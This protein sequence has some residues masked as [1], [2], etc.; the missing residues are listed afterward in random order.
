MNDSTPYSPGL[1]PSTDGTHA[2]PLSHATGFHTSDARSTTSNL[3]FNLP[4]HD[5][6]LNCFSYHCKSDD[7][8]FLRAMEEESDDC[9]RRL[10]W[11][12]YCIRKAAP[13]ANRSKREQVWHTLVESDDDIWSIWENG[14]DSSLPTAPTPEV[15][16]DS[17]F[18]DWGVITPVISRKIERHSKNHCAPKLTPLLPSPVLVQNTSAHMRLA[19]VL[20]KTLLATRRVKYPQNPS[21]VNCEIPSL[22]P[23]WW[24]MLPKPVKD[25]LV[26]D[27]R[28]WDRFCMEQQRRGHTCT[29][30]LPEMEMWSTWIT[31]QACIGAS[32]PLNIS[33]DDE[34]CPQ[35][36]ESQNILDLLD[37]PYPYPDNVWDS[38]HIISHYSSWYE[39]LNLEESL[40]NQTT[41]C[42]V[43]EWLTDIWL[44]SDQFD[45]SDLWKH[46]GKTLDHS[47]FRLQVY[48]HLNENSL[49]PHWTEIQTAISKISS[50]E[51]SVDSELD[52]VGPASW[53]SAV[54]LFT[55]AKVY[56]L[57]PLTAQRF[58]EIIKE[59]R[60][61]LSGVRRGIIGPNVLWGAF[62]YSAIPVRQR[63]ER[64]SEKT[65][66]QPCLNDFSLLLLNRVDLMTLT[67][68]LSSLTN[69]FQFALD[70][71]EGMN[72][73][74][75][76]DEVSLG[77]VINL[78]DFKLLTKL[79]STIQLAQPVYSH[80]DN[81]LNLEHLETVRSLH[82]VSKDDSFHAYHDN[83]SNLSAT[84]TASQTL[85][86]NVIEGQTTL[87][88]PHYPLSSTLFDITLHQAPIPNQSGTDYPQ[89][90]SRT[91]ES[92]DLFAV[93]DFNPQENGHGFPFQESRGSAQ[94][95][96]QIGDLLHRSN[97]PPPPLALG[98]QKFGSIPFITET[99][100][101]H[102]TKPPKP[103]RVDKM[104]I[105][106]KRQLILM[107]ESKKIPVT[108]GKLPWRNLFK[109]L[110]EHKCEFENWPAGT[111]E[112]SAQNG[113][114]KA[115]QKEIKSIYTALFDKD[116]PL[117]IRRIDGQLGSADRIFISQ[118]PLGSGSGNERSRDELEQGTC[119]V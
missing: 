100:T 15:R 62:G 117:R 48:L 18:E 35:C 92:T 90:H 38:P 56:G 88:Y 32:I 108:R 66:Q 27:D 12:L 84:Q 55:L 81:T 30:D 67:K 65:N 11:I 22:I 42:K 91:I 8:N 49:E 1:S 53:I 37:H 118:D 94:H 46:V 83:N 14:D 111:P 101:S 80:K 19:I 85:S 43:D 31:V 69:L 105:E 89:S 51:S 95:I 116:H 41:L 71:G 5:S 34:N 73:F 60:Y 76:D 45:H 107:L 52:S 98:G 79:Q 9:R 109:I 86:Q 74:D 40:F 26:I 36:L 87:S 10:E 54:V 63:K 47:P 17:E 21:S 96:Q 24:D 119:D 115:L 16:D 33:L 20:W 78:I 112:P 103:P 61:L 93:A 77:Y 58:M 50:A 64:K 25:N 68:K 99:G 3:E 102:N 7:E 28:S 110:Q 97:Y 59:D 75:S 6:C 104:R 4:P 39:V 70:N 82:S 2:A 29:E 113:I 57:G 13:G 23:K 106:I 72:L 114:E 44:S